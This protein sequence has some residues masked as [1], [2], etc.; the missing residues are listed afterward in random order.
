MFYL[1]TLLEG[2]CSPG[3]LLG[4]CGHGIP[5]VWVP[6]WVQNGWC[7][8]CMGVALGQSLEG[9]EGPPLGSDPGRSPVG[10]D[11]KMVPPCFP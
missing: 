9:P 6:R 7:G 10:P 1:A 11:L 8:I 3:S 4:P 5:Q 2:V